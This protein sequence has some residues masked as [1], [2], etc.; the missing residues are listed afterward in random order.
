MQVAKEKASKRY[1]LQS[2]IVPA[3][4][5]QQTSLPTYTSFKRVIG[6]F[7]VLENSTSGSKLSLKSLLTLA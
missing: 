1:G 5:D 6:C 3:C 4:P 2:F 7:L